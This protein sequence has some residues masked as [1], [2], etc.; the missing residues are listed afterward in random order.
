[1]S[2]QAAPVVL[3]DDLRDL[4]SAIG[5]RVVEKLGG[6]VAVKGESLAVRL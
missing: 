4:G 5:R 3:G 1:V 6:S 2:A